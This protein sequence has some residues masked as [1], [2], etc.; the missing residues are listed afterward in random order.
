MRLFA[1][2]RRV[3]RRRG[4]LGLLLLGAVPLLQ[5]LRLLLVLPLQG[6][7]RLT[8]ALVREVSVIAFLLLSQNLALLVLPRL[9]LSLLLRVISL[10]GTRRFR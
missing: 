5:L 3:G 6:C 4:S 2:G 10:F 7:Q 1:R 8:V 9:K